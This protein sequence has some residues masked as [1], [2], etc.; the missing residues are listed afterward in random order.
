MPS[1]GDSHICNCVLSRSYGRV[2]DEQGLDAGGAGYNEVHFLVIP[3]LLPC[4][5][6]L[7]TGGS[8]GGVNPALTHNRLS[9]EHDLGVSALR[10]DIHFKLICLCLMVQGGLLEKVC[11]LLIDRGFSQNHTLTGRSVSVK[12]LILGQSMIIS[13]R[14][15]K[16]RPLMIIEQLPSEDLK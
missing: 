15:R 1:G 13:R 6:R 10:F 11:D 5:A 14:P 8:C 3:Y 9:F 16:R 12:K 2:Q 7:D 4:S